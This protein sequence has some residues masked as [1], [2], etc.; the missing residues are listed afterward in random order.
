VIVD[1]TWTGLKSLLTSK[2]LP[3]QLDTSVANQ[4]RLFA[5]ES[6]ITYVAVI[7]LNTDN[8][9]GESAQNAIDKADFE[10]NYLAAVNAAVVSR[11]ADGLPLQS[12]EPRLGTE[13]LYATHNYSDKTTWF[14]ESVR[15]DGEVATDDGAGTTWSLANAFVIDMTHGK[16]FDEAQY[17]LDQQAENPSDPHGYAV[18]VKVDAVLQT[19]RAPFATSGG[20]YE[21]N[22]VTGQI[23]FFVSKAGQAVTVDYSYA[24]GSMFLI[25]PD[26]GTDIDI[27]GAKA[28]WSDN[29]VMNDAVSFEV[30]GYAAVFAPQLGLPPGTKIPIQTTSYLTLTQLT[31]EAIAYY[32][33][34]VA[35]C[36]GAR[37][38]ASPRHAVEFRY[39]TIRR[40]V[41]AVGLELHVRLEND[42]V[43]GGEFTSSTF[44]CTVREA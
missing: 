27:E 37:G 4:Y 42:I 24:A 20:D 26:D 23:V 25:K 30:W 39:G 35:A 19:A 28:S 31:A 3:L 16:T 12:V 10:A 18:V 13:V 44:Y 33:F 2:G 34:A 17:V 7:F 9:E 22:Y 1:V 43:M 8:I 14:G 15:V 29:F 6:T 5:V 11:N 40:L 36:G 41:S 38:I 32:P 21:V